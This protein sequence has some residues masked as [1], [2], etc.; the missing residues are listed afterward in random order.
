MNDNTFETH[1][2]VKIEDE[3][4]ASYLDYAMSVIV[5]RAL[6]DVRDGLKPVHRRIL[7]A[8]YQMGITHD[9]PYKKSARVVGEVLG[10]YH[11]HGDSASYEALVRMAQDFSFRYPL[12]DGHGNFGSVDG[13]APAAMRYTEVRLSKIAEEL[14]KDIEKNTVDFVPNFDGSLK[15]PVVLPSRFPN[16]LVNG[17]SGIAVGMATNM[18][19]H[20]IR[21]IID[22][23]IAT[24]DNPNITIEEL[25]EYIQG[26]DFPTGAYIVG[27]DQ[28]KEAYETGRGKLRVRAKTQIERSE[29]GKTS[30]VITEIPYQVNKSLLLEN[31]AKFV[32]NKVISNIT[33]LR[34]ESDREGMRIV[35]ELKRGTNPQVVL[36]QLFKHTQLETTF[37]VISIALIDGQ[38]KVLSLKDLIEEFINHRRVVVRRR[39]EYELRK[40][41]EKAHILEGLKIALDHLDEIISLIRR[42]KSPKEAK[43]GLMSNFGLTDIQA[44]A[45]LDLKLQRLTALER[46]KIE[47]DYEETMRL[48]THLEGILASE[49]KILE[50]IKEE[51]ADIK[52][53]YGDERRTKIIPDEGNKDISMED[54]I[55]EEDVVISYTDDGYIKRIPLRAYRS[56]KRGGTGSSGVATHKKDFV[57]DIFVCS[58]LDNLL[59]FTNK[60][61]VYKAMAYEVPEGRKETRGA[62]VANVISLGDDE[63]LTSVIPISKDIQATLFKKYLVMATKKGIIKKVKVDEFKNIRSNGIKAMSLRDDDELILVVL[64]DNLNNIIFITKN[65]MS[66]HMA[67]N[68]L[69]DLGRSA[70]GVKG[71]K[72]SNNDE[73]I[74]L[75]KTEE[76]KDILVVTEDGYGKRTPISEYR[77]QKRGGI[78]IKTIVKASTLIGA[79]IVDVKDDVILVTKN[80]TVI[81]FKVTDIR[82]MGRVTKGVRLIRLKGKDKVVAIAKIEKE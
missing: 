65:G 12:I 31:I 20:N 38:P 53:R 78:G 11:P 63:S 81:R 68:E 54:L 7:Y 57:K 30:I 25:M 71:I 73:V 42:S 66:L 79:L 39:T 58:T 76:D 80:G 74:A 33:D 32:Q 67:V 77:I 15:E 37:G 2:D 45:I 48:I 22:G 8:M 75:L 40:A 4:K 44:Q 29:S 56:Q 35:V 5:G 14:L 50:I 47:K 16:L 17:S 9:K 19:P 26:P 69:R 64:V 10:K 36:N 60:G 13:D 55:H 61:K 27:K 49:V 34:D 21:E 43:D 24:I 28:I 41:K 23:I 6:P 59:F 70:L 51:L 52:K 18:P 3:M 72:L 82:S 46:E 62:Y 1:L